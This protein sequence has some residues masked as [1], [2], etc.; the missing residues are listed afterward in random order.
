MVADTHGLLRESVMQRI[1]EAQAIVHAGDVGKAVVLEGLQALAPTF[2]VRGNVD[3]GE[4]GESLPMS[5][6]VELE[7][8]RLHV[9]RDIADLRR[10]PPPPGVKL[11]VYGHSHA[12]KS[13]LRDGIHYLNPGSIGPRRFR[14]P[15]SYAEVDWQDGELRVRMV[16]LES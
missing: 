6:T 13:E 7:G 5:R 9:I 16:E 12:P 3:R 15:I 10:W 11:V 1:G 4:L 8:L 2:A 14:L